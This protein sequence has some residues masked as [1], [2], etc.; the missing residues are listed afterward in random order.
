MNFGKY[1][2]NNTYFKNTSKSIKCLQKMFKTHR[3]CSSCNFARSLPVNFENF[4]LYS[5]PSLVLTQ[6]MKLYTYSF[7]SSVGISLM[8]LSSFFFT[9]KSCNNF[10]SRCVFCA[11][12][13]FYFTEIK[14]STEPAPT[15]LEA[16]LVFSLL[17]SEKKSFVQSN[18]VNDDFH[19]E[20]SSFSLPIGCC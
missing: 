2:I 19:S 16:I 12:L 3:H 20:N 8:F 5:F 9:K 7:S 11:V 6:I 17:T 1:K 14:S 10:T 13:L 4:G 15:K 18:A